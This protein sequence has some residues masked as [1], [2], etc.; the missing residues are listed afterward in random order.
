LADFQ[1]ESMWMIGAWDN[2]HN[3]T[4]NMEHEGPSMVKAQVLLAM[5][6]SKPVQIKESLRKARLVLGAPIAAS[7]PSGHHCAYDALVNL[8]M[9]HELELIHEAVSN[10]PPSSQGHKSAIVILSQILSACLDHTLSTFHV[11]ESLL[12]MRRTAFSLRQ[13]TSLN[14]TFL[15]H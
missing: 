10:L 2:V 5:Q 4:A 13:I 15:L 11:H 8:H 14:L 9:I 7:G 1:V 12:S 6:S 3:I